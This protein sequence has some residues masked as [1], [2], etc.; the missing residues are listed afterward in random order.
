VNENGLSGLLTLT[1]SRE[2]KRDPQSNPVET[3]LGSPRGN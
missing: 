2:R 1:Q 3:G